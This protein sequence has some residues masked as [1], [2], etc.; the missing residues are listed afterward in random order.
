MQRLGDGHE[1][2]GSRREAA[3]LGAGHAVFHGRMGDRMGDLRFAGVAR[4]HAGE[5]AREPDSG[6]AAPA[7]A[8]PRQ[9][10]PPHRAREEREQG[11]GIVRPERGV[12]PGGV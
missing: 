10:M 8:V 5:M 3:L 2:D 7:R 11:V 6:L 4:D 12:G 9:V 1:I